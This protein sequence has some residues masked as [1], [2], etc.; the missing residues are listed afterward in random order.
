LQVT[1]SAGDPKVAL[2]VNGRDLNVK[3]PASA[4]ASEGPDAVDVG[5]ADVH[6]TYEA[7]AARADVDFASAHGGELHVD[8]TARV[9]LAYPAVSEGIDAKKIPVRGKIV[10]KDFDV[11]WIARFNDQVETLGG[12]VSADAKVAGTV[13]APQFIGDVRWKNGKVVTVAPSKPAARR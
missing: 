8:A 6:L 4:D 1:G 9:N 10:A 2:T 7:R 13:G 12:R 11:A 5:H 3:R